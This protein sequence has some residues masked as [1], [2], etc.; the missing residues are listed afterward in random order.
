VLGERRVS[1]KTEGLLP[2]G[3]RADNEKSVVICGV[4]SRSADYVKT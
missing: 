2:T 4:M 1:K 3:A